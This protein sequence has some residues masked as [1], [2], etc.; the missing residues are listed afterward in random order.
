MKAMDLSGLI[1]G[2]MVVIGIAMA[3]GKLGALE[4]W[5]AKEAFG[6][7]QTKKEHR[8]GRQIGSFPTVAKRTEHPRRQPSEHQKNSRA[9]MTYSLAISSFHRPT[10]PRAMQNCDPVLAYDFI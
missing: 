6:F 1:K 3:I 8:L 4:R 10:D 5:A 2:L 7:N 9:M